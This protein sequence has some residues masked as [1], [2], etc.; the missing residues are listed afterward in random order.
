MRGFI[1]CIAIIISSV[2]FAQKETDNLAALYLSDNTDDLIIP[3]SLY[4][5]YEDATSSLDFEK[6][7]TKTFTKGNRLINNPKHNFWIKI[8]IKGSE[9][10]RK[11]FVLEIYNI[12]IDSISFYSPV[13]DS[14][15]T[16]STTGYKKNF[17]QREYK[18]INFTFDIDGESEDFQYYYFKV[19]T[20]DPQWLE[21]HLRTTSYYVYYAV[22]EYYL[23]G[24]FY[25]IILIM[26]VYNFLI[27]FST[28]EKVYIYYVIYVLTGGLMTLIEDGTGFAYLW[29]N[30]PEFSTIVSNYPRLLW[31]IS[32][33]LYST[34]FLKTRVYYPKW[35]KYVVLAMFLKIGFFLIEKATGFSALNYELYILPM[36]IL[37]ALSYLIWLKK[38][39]LPAK[40]FV[41][42]FSAV[43][44]SV[45]LSFLRDRGYALDGGDPIL[46]VIIVYSVN[47]AFVIEI[48]FLSIALGNR[49]KFLKE[50]RERAQARIIDQLKENE[51][52]KDKVNRELEQKVEER[53]SELNKKNKDII[54]SITYAQR[55]QSS[56]LPTPE[57]IKKI[58]PKSE[59]FY[60][61]KDIVSGD[62]LWA[63]ETA[64]F[65]Y[66][67]VVD[68]TGHGVPGALMSIMAN[69]NLNAILRDTEPTPGELLKHLDTRVKNLIKVS[70]NDFENYGMDI[71]VVAIEKK[72]NKG[73]YA[74][75]FNPL[76]II[77]KNEFSELIANRYPVGHY[78]FNPK[79]KDFET[80]EFE[81]K[82]GSKLYLFSDGFQD[83]FGGAEGDK[84]MKEPFKKLMIESSKQSIQQQVKLLEN[85]FDTWKGTREQIDDVLV[86][87]V[88]V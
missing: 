81:L 38:G 87:V 88:E 52:L 46:G 30:A 83:Q 78:F 22:T 20:Q 37:Y 15:Y 72:T 8:A 65:I 11:K 10:N 1:L 34:T 2:S 12:H 25:G 86:L 73:Y 53:T 3:D 68:C 40:Y 48:L 42:G 32:F 60:R 58:L 79:N 16:T 29:P 51:Q 41:Y 57:E 64:H 82:K 62:F 6:I 49:I 47:I 76:W 27:F 5:F 45:V 33:V 17:S 19:N 55:I 23:L 43:F 21:T 39:Y 84:F 70:E 7:R 71:S 18:T 28:K 61:P 44:V 74:G 54:D 26:A 24:F 67:A 75:A 4:S 69:N 36:M 66:F 77:N 50:S 56:V 9:E 13:N 59:V 31:M 35:N 63:N 80:R 14:T 85:T